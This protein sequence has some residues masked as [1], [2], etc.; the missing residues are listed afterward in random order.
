MIS[1]T[2]IVA[3]FS[4]AKRWFTKEAATAAIVAIA[5]L[6]VVI[7]LACI[8]SDIKSGAEARVNWKW[9]TQLSELKRKRAEQTAQINKN[10]ALAAAAERDAALINLKDALE[11]KAQLEAELAT[12]KDNPVLYTRDE[13]RRLFK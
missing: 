6:A 13:R 4:G 2:G 12:L 7:G 5:I 10:I 8:R 3:F 9:L 1:I 11:S